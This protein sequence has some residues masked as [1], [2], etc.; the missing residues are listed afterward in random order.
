MNE[1]RDAS[2]LDIGKNQLDGALKQAE[3]SRG[4][5]NSCA[6]SNER[7]D[8]PVLTGCDLTE[9]GRWEISGG[10]ETTTEMEKPK[11]EV[12]FEPGELEE[13]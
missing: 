6:E 3:R 11:L 7:A 9:H 4:S 5:E 10:G 1:Q 2:E 12:R 13:Q 8:G